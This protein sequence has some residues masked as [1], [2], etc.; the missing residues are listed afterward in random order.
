MLSTVWLDKCIIHMLSTM[1]VAYPSSAPATVR[2]R[3]GDGTQED[4]MCPP[5]L[6]DYQAYIEVLT[7]VTSLLG[8]TIWA[9]LGS[10]GKGFCI[11]LL[12]S[13]L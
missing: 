10:G 11:T 3:A 12:K 7:G 4:V 1:H 9:G 8:I 5:C 13:Q 6:P 2:R